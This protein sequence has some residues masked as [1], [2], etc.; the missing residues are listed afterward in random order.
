MRRAQVATDGGTVFAEFT[1]FLA[2]G[3]VIELAAAVV[4]GVAF[5]PVV[6]AVVERLLMPLVALLIGQPNF[7]EVGTFACDASGVCAGSAGAVV[8]AIVNFLLV[9]VAVFL[10]VKAYGR[11][12]RRGRGPGATAG[13]DTGQDEVALLREIRDAL[14]A[15]GGSAPPAGPGTAPPTPPR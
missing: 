12:A 4:L 8:T 9:A 10:I 15:P 3:K 5:V 2:R 11:I 14:V 13:S 7:D 6:A 1:E